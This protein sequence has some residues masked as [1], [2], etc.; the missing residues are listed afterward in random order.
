MI[1]CIF[2]TTA[3]KDEHFTYFEAIGEHVSSKM[4]T[5][6]LQTKSFAAGALVIFAI[7][8]A[9]IV[10]EHAKQ[11]Y[12]AVSSIS[13]SEATIIQNYSNVTVNDP[14]KNLIQQFL[15]S[16]NPID[17]MQ[18]KTLPIFGKFFQIINVRNI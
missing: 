10:Y 12:E 5:Q 7:Y 2:L 1:T 16:V 13:V 18:W 8:M 11:G 15:T 3:F 9:F 4:S 17:E 6:R 14:N